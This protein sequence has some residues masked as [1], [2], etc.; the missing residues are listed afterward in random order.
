MPEQ[1]PRRIAGPLDSRFRG[2]DGVKPKIERWFRQLRSTERFW[3]PNRR[4][5]ACA[6]M[7]E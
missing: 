6:G 4:T 5:A 2:N 3:I 1:P 7:T